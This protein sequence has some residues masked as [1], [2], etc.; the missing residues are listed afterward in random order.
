[1]RRHEG[2]GALSRL[3]SLLNESTWI[4]TIL[5]LCCAVYES[6]FS[7]RGFSVGTGAFVLGVCE[8]KGHDALRD[9]RHENVVAWPAFSPQPL[10]KDRGA[11]WL[12]KASE[13]EPG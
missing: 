13:T 7:K 5:I 8:S 2:A 6:I 4:A 11:D 1:M 3:K 10:R 9:L 12:I